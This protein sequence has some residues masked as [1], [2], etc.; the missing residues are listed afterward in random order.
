MKPSSSG[1][2]RLRPFLLAELLDEVR[3]NIPQRLDPDFAVGTP[4]VMLEASWASGP[5]C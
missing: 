5:A 4:E 2:T 3:A 1:R